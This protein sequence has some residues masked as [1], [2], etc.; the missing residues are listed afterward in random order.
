MHTEGNFRLVAVVGQA[1]DDP[2]K[3]HAAGFVHAA[4][5]DDAVEMV[6]AG[7]TFPSREDAVQGGIDAARAL[8]K[9]LD[10]DDT[11]AKRRAELGL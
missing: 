1:I 5:E 9:T 11:Y 8:A 3:W 4:G 10:P 7:D 2:R 6:K